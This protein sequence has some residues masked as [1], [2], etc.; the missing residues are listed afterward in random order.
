MMILN[1]R[2]ISRILK[3]GAVGAGTKLDISGLT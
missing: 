1:P 2:G 3:A